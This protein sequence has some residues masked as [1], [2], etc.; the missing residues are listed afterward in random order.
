MSHEIRTPINVI[1]NISNM[2]LEDYY[3]EADDD[4]PSSFAILDSAGKRI[5]RTIDLILNMSDIQ[6][7]SYKTS[8]KTFDLF[9]EMY[10]TF[11]N[12]F[13]KLADE[14]DLDFIWK[15]ESNNTTISGD[16]YSISQIF[17]NI[18]HNAIQFTHIGEIKVVFS[19]NKENKLVVD[20]VDTGI[21]ISEQFLPN[22]FNTF[23]QEDS[24]HTRKYE[25]NGLGMA[26]TKAYCELNKIKIDIISK[27]GFGST[28]SLTFLN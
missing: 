28:I 5:V 3:F 16:F 14:K 6:I 23:S 15:K 1:L 2:I 26:L 21:G 25:G 24:G 13:K 27:K 22:I 4:R 19:T 7:G 8:I 12:E 9:S 20:F 11:F 18:L 17:S 10:N